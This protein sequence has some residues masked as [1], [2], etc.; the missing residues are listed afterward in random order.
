MSDL[1]ERATKAIDLFDAIC[2]I[3]DPSVSAHD[4]C[5]RA[6]AKVLEATSP[7]VVEAARNFMALF[8]EDGIDPPALTLEVDPNELANRYESLSAALTAAIGAEPE[9]DT[10]SQW[11]DLALQFDGH[12]IQAMCLLRAIAADKAG[13][14][15]IEAFLSAPPLS[16]EQVL[17]DR[18][19]A[20]GAG[21]SASP[22]H[23]ADLLHR[24]VSTAEVLDSAEF[25]TPNI[26][27][28]RMS[29]PAMAR[30]I[31]ELI[32]IGAGGQAVAERLPTRDEAR[33]AARLLLRCNGADLSEWG[34]DDLHDDSA[35]DALKELSR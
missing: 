31:R 18:I 13:K 11:R 35:Q 29:G 1:I 2:N 3:H 24:A 5:V 12:R 26:D 19:A 32:A 34:G 22:T 27:T 16:G 23:G 4:R 25:W 21:Q 20:I 8:V 6:M 10:E 33:Q 14:A 28:T 17:A 30:T 15:E 7:G 9:E